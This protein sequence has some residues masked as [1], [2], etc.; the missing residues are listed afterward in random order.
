MSTN[1]IISASVGHKA[2]NKAA[3]VA[4]VVDLMNKVPQAEGGPPQPIVAFIGTHPKLL[5]A[6]RRFQRFHFG[7]STGTVEPN[8]VT[9]AKLYH[10]VNG[11]LAPGLPQTFDR[12]FIQALGNW[13]R[14]QIVKV[15]RQEAD[16]IDGVKGVKSYPSPDGP[17]GDP[18]LLQ[19]PEAAKRLKEY[20]TVYSHAASIGES[21]YRQGTPGKVGWCGVFATWT[22]KQ[23]MHQIGQK[24]DVRF[25]QGKRIYQNNGPVEFQ[26]DGVDSI[27]LTAKTEVDYAMGDVCLVKEL[28]VNERF[29]THHFIVAENPADAIAAG[30]PMK[31]IEGNY[32]HKGVG[33]RHSVTHHQRAVMNYVY[34]SVFRPP[35][36]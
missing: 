23:A 12:A 17:G 19:T 5:Q 34:W 3:D 25:E 4:T 16:R 24:W 28:G 10:I 15:A 13:A 1:A 21:E 9:I 14:S 33:A 26:Q 32:P 35:A 18:V 29:P 6:I 30:R 22:V 7:V 36:L 8:N 20:F 2:K 11:A 27:N 31:T